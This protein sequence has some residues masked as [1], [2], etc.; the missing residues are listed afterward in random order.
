MADVVGSGGGGGE[1]R[2]IRER[3]ARV[4]KR[5]A[6]LCASVQTS[7][8]VSRS[9]DKPVGIGAVDALTALKDAH[10]AQSSKMI[11]HDGTTM[12][13]APPCWHPV[14]G[15]H[16][17]DSDAMAMHPSHPEKDECA[18]T[19][20]RSPAAAIAGATGLSVI[21]GVDITASVVHGQGMARTLRGS[22][23][24][25]TPVG[26][27]K[28]L[29][30]GVAGVGKTTAA[31]QMPKPYVIDCEHGTD[32]YGSLIL[33]QEGQVFHANRMAEV[34]EEVRT[35]M[36][37]DH[38][39]LTLVIDPFT[40]LYDQALEEG[41]EKVGD[42]FNKH[43]AYANRMA[44]RMYKM[45]VQLDMNVILICHAKAQYDKKSNRIAD[46]F[47]G[48]K[49]LDYLFDL[50]FEI[51]R[52]T[53]PTKRTAVVRKTRVEAFPDG[54]KFVWG[55]EELRQR[56]GEGAL[57]R[58]VQPIEMA[59]EEELTQFLGLYQRMTPEDLDRHRISKVIE[60]ADEARDLPR[61]RI[62]RGIEV[63]KTALTP[64]SSM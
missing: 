58:R 33:E 36:T 17:G 18:R 9:I 43:F 4:R 52:S 46:T 6:R 8:A 25:E 2:R 44:K 13:V 61:E 32:W 7:P 12:E 3:P 24:A 16:D 5:S 57:D 29:F 64:A 48:W 53:H 21:H 59:S 41:T 56:L 15:A 62:L 40:M 19:T 63:M 37:T 27:L 23:P 54:A 22:K 26:R 11:R 10:V 1:A 28:A 30:F 39:F 38:E 14:V 60:T 47:D 51:Q 50:V 20:E 49:R 35:L 45:L 55:I 34:I 42:G 31:C